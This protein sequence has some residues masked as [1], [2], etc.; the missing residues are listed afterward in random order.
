MQLRSA[1]GQNRDQ[2]LWDPY[3]RRAVHRPIIRSRIPSSEKG[4]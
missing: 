2:I 1:K 3:A 4:L